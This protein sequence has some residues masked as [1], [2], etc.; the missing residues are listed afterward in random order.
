MTRNSSQATRTSKAV[1]PVCLVHYHEVGLKGRNRSVFE[2][3]LKENIEKRLARLEHGHYDRVMRISGR[4]LVSF[5]T[6]E[7]ACR[8]A[9]P[10]AQVPGVVRVSIGLRTAQSL[11]AATDAALWLLNQTAPWV[12]FKVNARRANTDFP[13]DSMEINRRIGGLLVE[14]FPDRQ[15]KMREPDRMVHVEMIEGSAFTYVQTV[16]GVG[17]LPVGSAGRVVSLL[18]AGLDSPVATFRMMRRGAQVTGLHFSGA[19]ETTST[20]EHLVREIVETLAP[21]GGLK[22]LAIVAFGSYQREIA[23]AVPS[24]LRVIF[25]RRLMFAVA[26]RLALREGAKALVTGES[27]GQ[28]ASQTLD[29]ILVVDAIAELPVLRP[30]IGTDKIEIIAEAHRLGTFEI[31]SQSHDDCCTLFMPRNPETHAKLKVVEP[32]WAALPV[33]EWLSQIFDSLEIETF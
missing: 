13:I 15:V 29:N 21:F 26:N 11:E 19:P 23:R 3:K 2:R 14:A 7:E 24:E 33:G 5:A 12:S 25:Y 28:V 4:L 30:L 6:W 20:S 31:S 16:K 9:E 8:A 27:L 22:R 17:G 1:Y 18:S 10:I 32:I